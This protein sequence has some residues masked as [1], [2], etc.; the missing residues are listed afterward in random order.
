MVQF[1]RGYP[2]KRLIGQL[3][4][5]LLWLGTTGFAAYLTPNPAGHGTHTQLGLNACPS[6]L[7]FSRPCP[8]CGLTTS[9]SAVVHGNPELAIRSHAFGLPLYLLFTVSALAC[10]ISYL[11]GIRMNTDSRAFNIA[12][13]TLVAV[14]FVYGA[15]RF[16]SNPNYRPTSQI[17]VTQ[18]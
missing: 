14:F 11:R 12:L 6:T 4:W 7:L 10:L 16:S 13:G 3:L 18:R 2:R 15:V 9:F 17:A 1:E 8:G 5:F